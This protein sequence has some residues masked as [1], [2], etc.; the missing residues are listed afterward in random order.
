LDAVPGLALRLNVWDLVGT[1]SYT[2]AFALIESLVILAPFVLVAA[3]LP[4]RLFKDHFIAFGSII[5][6]ISSVWM[7]VANYQRFDF[8]G[9]EVTQFLPVLALYLISIAIPIALVLRYKR[10]EGIVQAIIQRATVLAYVY[11]ALACIGVII[12]FVRNF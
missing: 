2:L 9:L 12:V 3:I 4:S 6:I 5:I 7:M 1:A 11:V 8:S 10:F